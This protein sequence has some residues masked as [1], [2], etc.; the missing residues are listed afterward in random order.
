MRI[1]GG[2]LLAVAAVLWAGSALG[3]PLRVTA[4]QKV[5]GRD[6][7]FESIQGRETQLRA[8]AELGS[9]G[10]T[11]RA[12]WDKNGDGDYADA[13]EGWANY[14]SNGFFAPLHATTTYPNVP[15]NTLIFPKVQ[16]ECGAE[17]ATAVMPVLIRIER[18]CQGYPEA[19]NCGAD[20][21]IRLTRKL[22]NDWAVDRGLWYMFRQY[23]HSADDGQGHATHTCYYTSGSARHFMSHGHTLLAFLRRGHGHGPARDADPYYRNLTKCGI[24]ATLTTFNPTANPDFDDINNR[25]VNAQYLAYI[26]GKFNTDSHTPTYGASAWAEPIAQFGDGSYVAEAGRA[27]VHGRRLDSIAQDLA[28][29]LVHCAGPNGGWYYSCNGNGGD[30]STNGWAP[31]ALRMLERKYGVETYAAAKNNQRSWL[32]SYCANGS[33]SYH[34]GGWKLSGNGL[35]GYGWV[36]NQNFNTGPHAANHVAHLNSV[37]TLISDGAWGRYDGATRGLYYIYASTKG[38]RSWVPEIKYLPNG[39]DWAAMLSRNLLR[40]QEADGSWNWTGGWSWGGSV[41]RPTRTGMT[42]Q[43]IQ[44]WLEAVAYARAT[45]EL[46]GPGVDITFDHSWSYLQDPS[47]TLDQYCWQVSGE[48]PIGAAADLPANWDFCTDDVNA[49]F[50]YAYDADLDWGQ[51]E[52]HT[53]TLGVRDSL[54]RWVYDQDSVEVK[55]SLLNHSPVVVPHPDGGNAFYRGYLGTN[56]VLDGRSSYDVDTNHEVFPGDANR[57]RGIPDRVTSIHFDLNIDGDFD[58]AGEDGTNGQVTFIPNENMDFQEGELFALPMRVCDDGQWNGECYDGVD[59]PDCTDC[60]Y[61]SAAIQ[62]VVNR[63]PP[64]IDIGTC[65]ANHE[66]CDPYVADGFDGVDIDLGGSFDPEGVLGLTFQYEL[67]EGRGR[68]ELAPEYRGNEANM[69]PTFTYIPEP[70]GPRTDRIR[71]RVT[72][73]AGLTSE[74]IIRVNVPNAAPI[75]DDFTLQFAPLAPN[76]AG[77]SI[78]NLGNGWYR[79]HVDASANQDWATRATVEARDP[80]ND[81]MIYQVD[82]DGNGRFDIDGSN[83]EPEFGTFLIPGG[84]EYTATVRVTDDADAV[85]DT[86]VF[87]PPVNN[88]TMQYFFDLGADGSFEVA[89]GAQAHF[90]FRAEPNQ[91]RVVVAGRVVDSNGESTDFD[92]AHDLV[93]R[94]PVFEVAR[95][96]AQDGFD[97]VMTASAVD[98]DGDQVTY[99]F[100]WGHGG[101]PTESRGGV[102]EQTYPENVFRAYTVRITATDGRGGSATRDVAVEFIA[103]PENQAPSIELARIIS[104]NGFEV[105]LTVSGSDPDNDA[106]NYTIQWGDDTEDRM[107]GGLAFH[108]YPDGQFRAYTIRVLV[109]DGRGGSDTVDVAVDF[110][111]PAANRNPIIDDARVLSQ[112]A[113]DVILTASATDPDDDAVVLSVDWGDD[114]DPTEMGGG[115][116]AH[117]FPDGVFAEYTVVVTADDGNGGVVTRDIVVAFEAPPPNE[118]PTFEF[119]RVI[120]KDG[121]DV[122]ISAAAVDPEGGAITYTVDW[123][124]GSQPSQMQ[125]GIADHAYP[126]GQFEEYTVTITAEDA[127]GGSVQTEITVNFPRPAD[128]R[129]PSFEFARLLSQDGFNAVIS[130]SASDPDNDVLTY[131]VNWGDGSE[132]VHLQ[133]GIAEHD[134]P[135]N[136]WRAYTVTITVEDGNGGSAETTVAVEFVEP[137]ANRAPQIEVARILSKDG[138]DV[139]VTATASDA[140]GDLLTYEVNWGDGSAPNAV[141]GGMAEHT[142]PANQ[143]RAYTIT[144]TVDDGNGG[145]DTAEISVNFPRPA[146]NQAPE[147]EFASVTEKVGFDVVVTA[148]AIDPDG[149]NVTYSVDWGDGSEPTVMRG[150][151]AAHSYP[152]GVFRAYTIR[153]TASDPSGGQAVRDLE[154]NFPAPAEN[155]NP[156]FE[157][158]QLLSK[159]G[160]TVVITAGAV[161]PDNDVV[162]YEVEW[163][164]GG[165]LGEL[166]G[167]VGEH[168]FPD[169]QF[170]NYTVTVTARDGN[171]GSARRT[172]DI[173]FPAPAENRPPVIE[174][175]RVLPQGGWEVLVV[176]GA[177]D[178]DEDSLTYTFNWGDG[179]E[180]ETNRGGIASHVF[181]EGVYRAYDITVTVDDGNGGTVE[182]VEEID[183]PEPAVN[184]PP[185]IE[186]IDINIDPR[187]EITLQVSAF[188]PEGGRL[189]YHIHWGDEP[190]ED[191]QGNLV[192]GIGGHTYEYQGENAE[193]YMGYVV[194]LDQHGN[195]TR[196]AF[197]VTIPDAPTA[198]L[199]MAVSVLR[200][201]TVLIEVV[202]DDRD[203]NA[204]L[205]YDFDF[206]GDGAWDVEG[207]ARGSIVHTY[208]QAGEYTVTVRITDTWSGNSVTETRRI[209]I[210]EWIADD[211]APVIGNID[212]QVGPRGRASVAVDAWDPEGTRL[213]YVIHW[214]DELGDDASVEIPGGQ[215]RHDYDYDAE[216][217]PNRG[218]VEVTDA[219]GQT[220]RQAFEVVIED[221]PTIIDQITA[222]LIRQATFLVSVSARDEDG[223]DRLVYSFDFEND[224]SWD[225]EDQAAASA[226][227]QYAAPGDYMVRVRVTDPWSGTSVEDV[228]EIT[229]EPW[230]I[231]NRGP[232]I[233]AV[234]VQ[235]HPRGR[236]TV[237]I[238]ASDPDND[239]ITAALH[240]GDEANEDMLEAIAGFGAEHGFAFPANGLPY[241][242]YVLVTDAN[243]ATARAEFVANVVDAPTA[244]REIAV[245]RVRDG[246]VLVN[247]VADD[248]DGR[249]QLVY[250]FDFDGDGVWDRADQLQPG[251]IN[252]FDRP[253]NYQI[254]VAVTDTWSGVTTEG[255][256]DIALLPWEAENQPPVINNIEVT[257]GIRGAAQIVVVARD[258]E[259]GF[260]DFVIHWGDE[261][262]MDATIPLANGMGAHT[263]AY[264]EDGGAYHGFVLVTDSEGATVR[265]EFDAQVLD[266][267]TE[268]RDVSLELVGG[269]TVLITVLAEDAD[270]NDQLVYGFDY[271]NDGDYEVMDQVANSSIFDFPGAGAHTVGVMVTD[272]WSG[273]SVEGEGIIELDEWVEENQPPVIR[274]ISVAISPRGHTELTIEAN[275][276]EGGFV[277][278]IVHWGDEA[279]LEAN[280]A[281]VGFVGSHDYAFPVDAAV[282]AGWV[283]VTDDQGLTARMAFEA[284]IVDAPTVIREVRITDQTS[285]QINVTVVA[286]DP[287][288]EALTYGFDFENDGAW[289]IE[290]QATASAEHTYPAAGTYTLNVSLTDDWSGVITE[291]TSEY[292]LAPWI[293][294]VPLG[295]DHLE[296][297][298]GAC[299]VFRVGDDLSQ[300][301]TKVDPTVCERA[302]NPEPELWS[303]AFGDGENARGSEVGHR[304]GDDG[305]YQVVVEGGTPE[306]RQRSEIQV[307]INNVAPSFVTAPRTRAIRGETYRYN[308][309][310]EDSGLDDEVVVELV[311]GAEGMVLG[312]GATDREWTLA[313]EVPLDFDAATLEVELRA[314]DGRRENGEWN[315]DGGESF[316]NF[317]VTLGEI[318]DGTINTD[319]DAGV[320]VDAGPN[321]G[322][323]AYTGSSCSCD[324]SDEQGPSGLFLVLL[325]LGVV[326]IRRRRK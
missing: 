30:A 174:E 241:D 317:E 118:D 188:D 129:A 135:A 326:T 112:D 256:T 16:V 209:V 310:L 277:E 306:R 220:V 43:I 244:I 24:N 127:D 6:I 175:V 212:V 227:H 252:T 165:E 38:L 44:S 35:V 196:E 149:D 233:H 208:P 84:Q 171:G 246:I 225:F 308:I 223:E 230:V 271:N 132:P 242:G 294:D 105:L 270:G 222:N 325:G 266:R 66:N 79:L 185:V 107:Q 119:A 156:I 34:H 211:G 181:P 97:V 151:T 180:P 203:G 302:E 265:G 169:G 143:F 116:A 258:P 117:T 267:P 318:G 54:G 197:E 234:D 193:P 81:D 290:S 111:A 14:A 187:G 315:S 152:D 236:T 62:I 166:P 215:G 31:E 131:T 278:A 75:I 296:G 3:A 288:T 269:G 113:F 91:D 29:G 257:M 103:P 260:L 82:V 85:T 204:G 235:V 2:K 239:R 262:D 63:E 268:I 272:I 154:V 292:E 313:W 128:N 130:A 51:V 183:F 8:I 309:R 182:Q 293:E 42:V 83:A 291:Q 58:D 141:R 273:A 279:E 253:G 100:D 142:Y 216:G 69:G 95:I 161:D 238:D 13:G 320:D 56:I 245:D 170:R 160:F 93:N 41:A 162:S 184:E 240:W 226:T 274:D 322:F 305:I 48:A 86:L 191:V 121:F 218:W 299:L 133:G 12:R 94:A 286:S 92:A 11:Y 120:A 126:D 47:V 217:A 250:S 210:E 53:A 206:E 26:N 109:E 205:V 148:S 275:D 261:D 207:Q 67:I 114:S 254:R 50:V 134:F 200:E 110:P 39:N 80:G 282:Y 199:D 104:K 52:R 192:A 219:A 60:A 22:Y 136:Q 263:F 221:N 140:D 285:G 21:N 27:G 28:D 99:S 316:Q 146:D 259:D 90:D 20:E 17:T 158:L 298:E 49:T 33:C 88:P 9:C 108:A 164:D 102:A 71:A 45:P 300:F 172:M 89:G 64:T 243:G 70:D 201:G 224:G 1:R 101:A 177:A 4:I 72:D 55:L 15:G 139:V 304:Y 46:A 229:L 115:L 319:V 157:F 228:V 168:T 213:T 311:R 138:F 281:L 150:G 5:Q 19:I 18:I 297:D 87:E 301:T 231:D 145:Q 76:V 74:E 125:G 65:D 167:G 195:Q 287:D 78:E 276:P 312:R 123:G 155:A 314:Y 289:E 323:D 7:P 25:G 23:T 247:I 59:R 124:D 189:T 57:A 37:Q 321:A 255:A 61:G 186:D 147:F 248:E 144:V 137:Q 122:V 163:G 264:P 232:V 280:M 190:A 68:I 106:L 32:G 237:V 176:V 98:P 153:I 40:R 198:V 249:D 96:L 10:N 303:W 214:G 77:T 178:A 307:Q 36:D 284:E 324:V 194:V 283:Q 159:D 173:D 179:S 295:G 73:F 202:A 251:S